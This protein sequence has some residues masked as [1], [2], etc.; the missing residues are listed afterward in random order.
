MIFERFYTGCLA[1]A[2]FGLGDPESKVAAIVDPRRDVE[3]YL[4]WAEEHGLEIRHVIL[5]HFHA[6]FLAGH[7]ELRARTGAVIHLGSQAK[8]EY[9]IEA[10]GD[11]DVLE[12]GPGLRLKALET[13][14]HTPEGICLLV[15]EGDA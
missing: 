3:I 10:L 2:S 1:Q 13:P 8:T 9:P 15:F 5:T 14:G 4:E 6:D 7:L 12:I 11:G